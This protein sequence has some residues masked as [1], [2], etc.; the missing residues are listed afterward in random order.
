MAN[1]LVPDGQVYVPNTPPGQSYP[2]PSHDIQ[3]RPGDSLLG[4][5]VP[6]VAVGGLARQQPTAGPV[7]PTPTQNLQPLGPGNLPTYDGAQPDRTDG[8]T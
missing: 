6:G 2:E 5:G 4:D 7:R 8:S 1:T 3:F